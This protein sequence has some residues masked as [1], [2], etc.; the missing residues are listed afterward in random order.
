MLNHTCV[1]GRLVDAPAFGDTNAGGKYAN[2]RVAWSEKYKEKEVKLYL[3]CKA[4]SGTAQFM[5]KYMNQKGQEIVVEGR[6]NTEEWEKD[7]QKRSKIV[8]VVNS[9][10][11]CG[12]RKDGGNTSEAPAQ[13]GGFTAVETGELPF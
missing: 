5:E 8:L 9:V 4:F 2:F 1:Q 12:S 6:L 10:H 11:F 7:G 3:D 13:Q